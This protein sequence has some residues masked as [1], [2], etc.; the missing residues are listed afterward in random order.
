MK[1]AYAYGETV[2]VHSP[3]K[4]K[5]GDHLTMNNDK[6]IVITHKTAKRVMKMTEQQSMSNSVQP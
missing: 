1:D 4:T 6:E 5:I 2:K 3:I